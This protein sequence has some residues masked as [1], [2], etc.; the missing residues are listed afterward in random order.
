MALSPKNSVQI[1]GIQFSSKETSFFIKQIPKHL[2]ILET[3]IQLQWKLTSNNWILC[4]SCPLNYRHNSKGFVAGLNALTH[5]GGRFCSSCSVQKGLEEK[6]EIHPKVYL[7]CPSLLAVPPGVL[8]PSPCAWE[9]SDGSDPQAQP[10]RRR[11]SCYPLHAL[12]P[13][14][15]NDCTET[16]PHTLLPLCIPKEAHLGQ[17]ELIAGGDGTA[18]P[19]G[20]HTETKAVS[21]LSF[22]KSYNLLAGRAGNR[23]HVALSRPDYNI[24]M[25]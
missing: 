15:G 25:D 8:R 3:H 4:L 13:L 22:Y 16:C 24:N 12:F 10:K 5:F 23:P 6:V 17:E 21:V 20:E 9:K 14:L 11:R 1:S 7:P 19:Q 2:E 18:V